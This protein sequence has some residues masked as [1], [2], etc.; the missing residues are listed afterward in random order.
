M[1]DPAFMLDSDICIYALKGVSQKLRL[2]F[3][4]QAAGTVALSS[5]SLAE[6]SIGYGEKISEAPDLRLFLEDLAVLDF[7]EAAARAYAVLP[8]RRGRFDRL[9]AAHALSRGLTLVT[10]NERD[11][12][13][14]AGLKIENWTL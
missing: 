1:A 3:A 12:A 11:F 9:V 4:E 14:V 5:I 13:D 7:D 8:F 6:V 10:N 2:R